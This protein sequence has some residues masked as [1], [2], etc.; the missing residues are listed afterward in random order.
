MLNEQVAGVQLSE[1][2]QYVFIEFH[3]K[4]CVFFDRQ[5]G[6]IRKT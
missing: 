1:V 6:F 4:R 5:D 2:V 3:A